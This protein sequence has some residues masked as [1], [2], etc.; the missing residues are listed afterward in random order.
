MR[1]LNCLSAATLVVALA[2]CGSSTRP[3]YTGGPVPAV[4]GNLVYRVAP[5]AGIDN[6]FLGDNAGYYITAN[7]GGSFR[8]VW[9][10]DANQSA[11]YRHFYGS[12]WTQGGFTSVVPGCNGNFCPLEPDDFVST[13]HNTG[14]GN[15]VDWDTFAA[16]G[17]DGFDFSVDTVPALF[18]LFI[19][20]Q[21][22]P[23]HVYFPATDAKPPGSVAN[24]GGFP[25]GLV[26]Q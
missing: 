25:F 7:T 15:R 23:D 11:V 20:N 9:T 12:V 3:L 26:P 14:N 22:F 16:D 2:G 5:G 21:Q 18:D 24:V 10:G 8:I 4:P 1:T 13:V 17:L 6:V 19:D